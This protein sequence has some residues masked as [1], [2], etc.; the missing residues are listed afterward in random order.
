MVVGGGQERGLRSGTENPA[1]IVGIARALELALDGSVQ[2]VP[3]MRRLR[4]DL[5]RGLVT[6]IDGLRISGAGA[7]RNANTL[8]LTLPGIE[9]EPLLVQLDREGI[10]VSAGAACSSGAL[11]ASHVLQAMAVEKDRIHGV[12]RISLSRESTAAEL[13]RVLELLPPMVE[14]L[15]A[16]G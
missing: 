7:D 3:R 5:A 9:A 4:D 10:A 6:A 8:H 11:M 2:A 13:D 14:R 1:G 15:R 12:L 16:L